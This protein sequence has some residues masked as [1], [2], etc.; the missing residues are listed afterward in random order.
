M[1]SR[2]KKALDDAIMEII[3]APSIGE[4]KIG[5][6]TGIQ[7]FKYKLDTQL[8]MVAYRYIDSKLLLTFIEH[9]TREN[10]YRDLKA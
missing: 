9:E 1:H 10:F 2:E 4:I 6:L 3:S 5:D 8:Y 7:V